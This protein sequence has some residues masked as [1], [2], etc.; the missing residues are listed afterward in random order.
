M[1]DFINFTSAREY[2]AWDSMHLRIHLSRQVV[3]P[4][5]KCG[6]VLPPG[7]AVHGYPARR[8][9]SNPFKHWPKAGIFWSAYPK[10]FPMML[11]N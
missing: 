7:A 9:R 1:K 2:I 6:W 8:D 3:S 10:S 4:N 11:G 5:T